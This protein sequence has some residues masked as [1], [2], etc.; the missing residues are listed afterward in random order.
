MRLSD[1]VEIITGVTTIDDLGNDVI[2]WSGAG[3]ITRSPAHVTYVSTAVD[4]S[5]AFQLSE[6][7][8]IVLP[9]MT[10]DPATQRIRWRGKTFTAN[11]DV[12]LRMRGGTLHHIT[13]PV[14]EITG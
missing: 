5:G 9:P 3:G 7:L 14:R 8:R 11:G 4:A 13:V 6:E 12:L 2:D 10:Y 1:R